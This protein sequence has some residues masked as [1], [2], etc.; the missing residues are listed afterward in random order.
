MD[1]FIKDLTVVDYA[2]ASKER[3]IIGNSLNTEIIFHGST[4]HEGV[5]YDFSLAKKAAKKIIDAG[6]DHALVVPKGHLKR[7]IDEGGQERAKFDWISD[8][9]DY[10]YDAPLQAFYEVDSDVVTVKAIEK[11]LEK[12]IMEKMPPNIGKITIRLSEESFE[13]SRPRYHYTHGLK[14]HYGNCQRLFHGHQN[15]IRIWTDGHQDLP[16]ER[17]FSTIFKDVHLAILENIVHVADHTGI[18]AATPEAIRDLLQ[19][20]LGTNLRIPYTIAIQYDGNQGRFYGILPKNT[21]SLL[22]RETT[23]EYIAQHVAE[24][25]KE[26]APSKTVTAQAFEGIG[27]GAIVTL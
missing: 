25:L 7:Y 18:L 9:G 26:A 5:V 4:D 27:K 14:T 3:G 21:V 17:L 16:S 20:Y 12:D 1:L 15:T 10:F 11:Q 19:D 8:V 6:P 24:T 2:Y 23:V 22:T 13:E